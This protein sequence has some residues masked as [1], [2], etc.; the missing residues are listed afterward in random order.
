MK[1]RANGVE[2]EVEADEP[3][4]DPIVLVMGIGA[5]LVHWPDGFVDSLRR[6]GFRVIRMDNRDCGLSSNLRHLPVP[7]PRKVLL[8]AALGLAITAPYSLGDMADDLAAVLDALHIERAHV[9]G[10]SMGGMISQTFALKHGARLRSLT[11]VMST[12]GDLR[13]AFGAKPHALK[14]LLG[15]P[16]RSREEAVERMVHVYTTIGS[17]TMPPEPSILRVL[18][19]RSFDRGMNPAGFARHFAAIGAAGSRRAALATLRVPTLVIHGTQDPLIPVAAGRATA[20]AIPGARYLELADM[21]HDL[22]RPLWG[23]ITS[24]VRSLATDAS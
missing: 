12:T 7:D 6:A 5:Q 1:V 22:P 17:R 4:G 10:V 9:L 18:G 19:E 24:A 8:R 2:I 21:G 3:G 20:R 11:S 23:A 16:P 15:K 14:A 13:Y